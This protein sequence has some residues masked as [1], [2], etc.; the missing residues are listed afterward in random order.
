MKRR[1]QTLWLLLLLFPTLASAQQDSLPPNTSG[2]FSLGVRSTVSLFSHGSLDEIGYGAGAHFRLQM[3]D[4]INTEWY[5]DV[6]NTDIGHVAG[7]M[8]YHIGWSVMFYVIHPRGFTRPVT[9]FVEAGHCFDYTVI[10]PN[11][12]V[13]ESVGNFSSAVQ[14]GAG[15][16]FNIT[17]R[18][19][20]SL[21]CQYMLHLGKELHAHVH[22]DGELEIEQHNNAGWEGHLLV[23]ISANYKIARLWKS[24]KHS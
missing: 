4:R 7:R 15:A 10:T 20:I 11:G 5:M 9:P 22:D 3:H 21:K 6:L 19:D 16:H 14:M 23:T 17:P 12:R 24:K 8:D 13:N 1:M 18:L 2:M